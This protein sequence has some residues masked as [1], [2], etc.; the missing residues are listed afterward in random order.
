MATPM[1]HKRGRRPQQAN[2]VAVREQI[3]QS[4]RSVFSD[5]GYTAATFHEIAARADLARA[6]LTYYFA[7]KAQLYDEAVA[8]PVL[9]AIDTAVAT[10]HQAP[11]LPTQLAA[12]LSAALEANAVG[13]GCG[14]DLLITAVYDTMRAPAVGA[15]GADMLHAVREFVASAVEDAIARGELRADTNIAAVADIVAAIMLGVD[16]IAS[17]NAN[18]NGVDPAAMASAFERLCANGLWRLTTA[19]EG[20]VDRG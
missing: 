16:V 4:A 3:V 9:A 14:P 18:G 1:R 17:D 2:G 5:V 13:R 11:T 8:Q 20:A 19:E 15:V 7:N 10:A 6:S 12:F